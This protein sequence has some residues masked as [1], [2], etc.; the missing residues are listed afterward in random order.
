MFSKRSTT[1]CKALTRSYFTVRR[2]LQNE[3]HTRILGAQISN[4]CERGDVISLQGDMGSG[5]TVFCQG[6]IRNL[7]RNQKL[8][9]TSPTFL[10]DNLYQTQD[11]T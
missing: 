1:L 8:S 6:F 7:T 3:E 10:L 4:L 9:V 5:K 2:E 11:G